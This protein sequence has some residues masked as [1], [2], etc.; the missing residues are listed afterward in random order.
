M[1]DRLEQAGQ[2]PSDATTPQF[3]DPCGDALLL[4]VPY[5]SAPDLSKID[6]RAFAGGTGQ[7]RRPPPSPRHRR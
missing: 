1:V 5:A 4:T 2:I 6:L 3:L 7:G